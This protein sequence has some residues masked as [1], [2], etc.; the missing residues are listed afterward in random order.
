VVNRSIYRRKSSEESIMQAPVPA[1]GEWYRVASGEL[2]EV[3][4]ID[5][6]DQSI[7]V[8]FFD[9]TLEEFDNETWAAEVVVEADA[10]EDW[11]GSVD[12]DQE[13]YEIE[14]DTPQN[15]V[16]SA[17]SEYLDRS[18]ASGYSEMSMG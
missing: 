1:V 5:A 6:H 18:E 12:I 3:V 17:P 8:Q 2:F 9:G 13:D 4:A 14:S 15:A 7:E 11:R 16:W 10:P